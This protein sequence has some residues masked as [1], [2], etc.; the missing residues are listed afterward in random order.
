MILVAPDDYELL[1]RKN[2]LILGRVRSAHPKKD[3]QPVTSSPDNIE[4]L[5]EKEIAP[6]LMSDDSS[7]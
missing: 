6:G 1:P 7:G 3:N 4:G 5:V 2:C